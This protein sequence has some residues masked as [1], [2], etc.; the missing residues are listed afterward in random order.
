MT[1]YVVPIVVSLRLLIIPQFGG[2]M[3][4]DEEHIAAVYNGGT[5]LYETYQHTHDDAKDAALCWI[6]D[7]Y[8]IPKS[9]E[10]INHEYS[11]G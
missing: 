2:D 7:Q 4:E 1:E 6:H 10:T 9:M 5:M 8:P 3:D 11:H